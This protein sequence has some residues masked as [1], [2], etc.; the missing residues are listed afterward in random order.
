VK[1]WNRIKHLTFGAFAAGISQVAPAVDFQAGPINGSFVSTVTTGFGV[2]MKDPSCAITGDAGAC[3]GSANYEQWSG[4][5]DGNLNYHKGDLFTGYLK[6]T[7][8]LLLK[9]PDSGLKFMARGTW[10]KDFKADDTR[11]SELSSEARQQIVNNIELLDFWLSKD[12]ALGDANGRI[13]VGN[14]V[15]SWGEALFYVGGISNNV[16][17]F[18]KLAVPGTQLKEAFLPIPAVSVAA[19]LSDSVSAEVFYQFKWRRARV[20][21]VGSYFSASDLYDKGRVPASFNG[22]NFNTS[23]IDQYALTGRASLSDSEALEAIAANGDFGAPIRAD[24]K[25]R[26]GGQ[27]GV[28]V[29]W[30]PDGT[31]FNLGAYVL[32]YHD[33]F[34]VLSTVDGGTAYQWKFLEDRLMYG[35]SANFPAGNWAIGTELSYRPHDA[36]T[37]GSCFLPGGALDANTNGAVLTNGCPLYKDSKKYQL[38]VTSMLQ[39]MPSE[40]GWLLKPLGANSG[41][42]TLEAALTRYPGAGGVQRSV[43]DGIAVEQYAA[44]GYFIPLDRSGTSSL[45]A[46]L[47]TTTSYGYVLDF[48][49]TYDGSLIPGWQVTPGVTFSHAVKGDTPNYSAQFLERNKSANFYLLFNQNP[50]KWQAGINYTA[51]FDGKNDVVERQYFK[52]RNFIGA[53]LSYNF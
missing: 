41:Y 48:N 3:G 12:F 16:L 7:H 51:Y 25:P 43:V 5:D 35:L 13:K 49:L 19:S 6:G 28:S 26:R 27:Y 23:G 52:D 46:R 2:R 8:E 44:A 50:V 34:P 21:P 37:L 18:Q 36:I 38:S 30:T 39:L 20:A 15:I 14:Q 53:F 40:H 17:D 22:A 1:K 32:N 29:H 47:G 31:P 33:Q 45:A 4:G 42:V 9:M 11:R 24:Q 10:K